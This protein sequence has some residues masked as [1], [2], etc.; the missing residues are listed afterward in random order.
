MRKV[1]IVIGLESYDYDSDSYRTVATSITD[2]VE[3]SD[4]DYK[5]LID[6]QWRSNFRVI[7][8]PKHPED[9]IKKTVAD[10]LKAAKEEQLRQEAEKKKREEAAL[11]RRVKKEMR[12]KE[13]ARKIYEELKKEF[14]DK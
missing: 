1:A 12:D 5:I 11:Q 6:N 8:Q 9:F 2:W 4:D 14:E 7:E 13:K 3:V 10:Y